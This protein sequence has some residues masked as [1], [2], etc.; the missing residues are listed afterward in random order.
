[1]PIPAVTYVL[2]TAYAA[3]VIAA[4][5]AYGSSGQTFDVLAALVAGGDR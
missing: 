1:M 5:V 2:S 4:K 3:G